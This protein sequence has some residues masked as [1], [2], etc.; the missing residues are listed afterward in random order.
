MVDSSAGLGIS[1]SVDEPVWVGEIDIA[2]PPARLG[3]AERTSDGRPYRLGRVLARFQAEPIGMIS[4]ELVDGEV[5]VAGLVERASAKFRPQIDRLAPGWTP[6]EPPLAPVS[7]ELRA[8]TEDDPPAISVV[9][10]TRNRPEQVVTCVHQVLKQEY[11]S[12]VEVIVVDNG[13]A[14]T[15]TATA[16]QHA[17]ERDDR[18]RYMAEARPGLSR[19]RNIGLAA[20]RYSI[21]AF[22]SDD[23]RVDSLWLSAV[24]RGFAR[25]DRV[26][27]VTGICPPMFLDTPEQILFESSMAWGTRQGFEPRLYGF[28]L[29]SDPV[30]PYRTGS[31]VNGSNMIY[32]TEIFRAM[33]GFDESLGPGTI[34][35]GGED[36]DAPIRI[37]AAGGLIAFE[38]AAIGWHADRYDDRAFGR[39]MYAYGLGLT[40]FLAKHL[41]EGESRRAVIRRIPGGFPLMVNAF[42]EPDQE[43]AGDIRI[44]ARYQLCHLAGRVAGPVAYIRSRRSGKR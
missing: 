33:G 37:L 31:F 5:D 34:A 39:H 4:A 35:R 10:G 22:L 30:H 3:T 26:H 13:A 38:P 25:H 12:P 20:A 21:T 7:K 8:A 1:F 16:I 28:E 6:A 27:C 17:F 11:P 14:D 36:L 15:S 19:A 18:V 23:I 40:A 29:A 41:S 43:M 32:D 44:P 24:A 9:I 42:G 2:S